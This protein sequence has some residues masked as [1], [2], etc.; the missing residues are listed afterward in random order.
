MRETL[1]RARRIKPPNGGAVLFSFDRGV[2]NAKQW[3]IKN[4][5]S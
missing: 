5:V 4:L 2:G 1:L 3:Q